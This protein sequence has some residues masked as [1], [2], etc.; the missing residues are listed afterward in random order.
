MP[1]YCYLGNQ[2]YINCVEKRLHDVGYKRVDA[3]ENADCVITYFTSITALEDAYFG[4]D[5]LVEA[6]QAGTIAVD[7][8]ASTPNLST[9]I[10]SVATISDITMVCSPLCVK[11]KLAKDSFAR[12]NTYTYAGSEDD[13]VEKASEIL[14]LLF[15]D[16][17]PVADA[18]AAQL[19]RTARTIQNTSEM[20]SAIEALALFDSCSKSITSNVDVKALEPHATSPEAYFIL[21]AVKERRFNGDY[22]VEMLLSEISAAM[23][24]ADDFEMILPQTEAAF[25][26]YELLA[27]IG[28]SDMSPAA[29]ILV[30]EGDTSGALDEDAAV[31]KDK[32]GKTAEDYGLDWSRVEKLYGPSEL[33]HDHHDHLGY[34]DEFL[35]DNYSEDF[36]FSVN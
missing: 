21:E 28:G 4:D 7:L 15:G 11:N 32:N 22:T 31:K 26:L 16:V 29:L 9:E 5:G 1:S 2:H 8:S 24:T 20:V 18:G 33:D 3:V 25:H 34:D 14:N 19:A 10:C 30:F 23:M 12:V 17:R 13:G 6:M 35:D 27:I 36:G